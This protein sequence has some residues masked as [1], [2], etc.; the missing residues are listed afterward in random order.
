MKVAVDFAPTRGE[1]AA[2]GQVSRALKYRKIKPQS[3]AIAR[4]PPP[5]LAASPGLCRG[6]PRGP[7]A[8]RGTRNPEDFSDRFD[9]SP[10]GGQVDS[11]RHSS[12]GRRRRHR[13]ASGHVDAEAASK[14]A[15]R[16]DIAGDDLA[17]DHRTIS[18]VSAEDTC[19][20]VDVG[21]SAN[22]QGLAH[23]AARFRTSSTLQRSSPRTRG[24]PRPRSRARGVSGGAAR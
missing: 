6:A 14:Q 10:R 2:R 15:I 8:G 1:R 7:D 23:P 24:A 22:R 13:R 19:G 4:V 11:D 5:I 9:G 20:R 16:L 17:R 21:P 3:Q 18:A 12:T